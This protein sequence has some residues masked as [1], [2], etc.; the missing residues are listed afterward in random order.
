[1]ATYVLV[2][3]MLL[4]CAVQVVKIGYDAG[5]LELQMPLS[6]IIIYI[7][8]VCFTLYDMFKNINTITWGLS[9]AVTMSAMFEIISN[10][11]EWKKHT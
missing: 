1:M 11:L 8:V 5:T 9:I 10:L 2:G 7:G 6:K 3:L 4:T